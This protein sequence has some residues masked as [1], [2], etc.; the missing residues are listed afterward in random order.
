MRQRSASLIARL[1][2][3]GSTVPRMRV[4]QTSC[5]VPPYGGVSNSIAEERI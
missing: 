4:D 1:P 2:R 5:I 3:V